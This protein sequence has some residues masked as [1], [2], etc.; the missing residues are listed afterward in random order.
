MGQTSSPDG[1]SGVAA[2]GKAAGGSG[3]IAS[4]LSIASIGFSAASSLMQGEGTASADTFKA[5]QL[6]RAAQYGTLKGTETNAQMT[7]N[8]TISLGQLD[9]IRAAGGADPTSPSGNA[10]RDFVSQTGTEQ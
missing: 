1:T 5:E 2:L 9:A 3:G 10:V 8:L 7:R 4:G 6:D